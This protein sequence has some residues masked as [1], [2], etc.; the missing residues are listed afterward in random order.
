MDITGHVTAAEALQASEEKYRHILENMQDAYIRADEKGIIS[1]A[2][3]SAARMY[4]YDSMEEMIGIPVASLYATSGQQWD[5]RS[6]KLQQA[7]G[8]TD[9]T[10]EAL[11]KDGTIRW[12]SL[13]VQYIKDREGRIRGTEE[14]VRDITDR[15]AMERAVREANEKLA[16]LSSIT[17]HDI[18]N[19][20][21]MLQGFSQVAAREERDPAIAG[22]IAKIDTAAVTIRRQIE[23]MKTYQ[24][25][26]VHTPGWSLIRETVAKVARQEVVFSETCRDIEVFS[27]PMLERV[28]FNLFENAMQHGGD[29]TKITVRCERAPD[30]LVIIVED[31][32]SGIRSGE[33]EKIFEKGFGKNTGLGLFLTKQ[34]LSITG[35][36][37]RE[38]GE[39]DKG[40]RFEM[41]VPKGAWRISGEIRQ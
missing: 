26:G 36:T 19:Q 16:L 5:E 4:G 11:R 33:K 30:T 18:A 34:I 21:T 32:G 9:F 27:D 13:N 41:T 2:N 20:L 35:I 37:I 14:I 24:D 28:F 3:P 6:G 15:K 7:G 39:P 22:Y 17:R 38:T 23:F 10:G 31:N 29:V 8:I 12:V 1:M 40:A 25:L